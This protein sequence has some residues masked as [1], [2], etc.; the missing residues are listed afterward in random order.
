[1]R[2]FTESK[3]ALKTWDDGQ[4]LS[5]WHLAP[6]LWTYCHSL[7]GEDRRIGGMFSTRTAILCDAPS[8]L[9]TIWS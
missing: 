6:G 2:N 8:Y 4:S 7:N 3:V 1:M 5:I 9:E